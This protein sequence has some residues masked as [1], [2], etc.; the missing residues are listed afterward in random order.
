MEQN[1]CQASFF[2]S[3]HLSNHTD[4]R[5]AVKHFNSLRQRAYICH[6][7]YAITAQ[8]S[9]STGRQPTCAFFYVDIKFTASPDRKTLRLWDKT[10]ENLGYY[11]PKHNNQYKQ[12]TRASVV[13]PIRPR[14]P[15]HHRAAVLST[16]MQHPW[17][18]HCRNQTAPN[19]EDANVECCTKINIRIRQIAAS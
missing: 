7:G 14:M 18:G 10:S 5:N 2:M 3:K 19:S 15:C 9:Q 4:F 13:D 8:T 17:K 12:Q 6:L 16:R 11:T 1:Y